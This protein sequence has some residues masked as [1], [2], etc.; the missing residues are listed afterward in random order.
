[1]A[2]KLFSIMRANDLKI[3]DKINIDGRVIDMTKQRTV[4]V[5]PGL[6]KEIDARYGKKGQ[7][8]PKTIAVG[9]S[10]DH[11]DKIHP[12]SFLV[13]DLPWKHKET[14]G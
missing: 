13:P 5:D 9:M 10:E 2:K 1:M 4:V 7:V 6:A 3:M 14:E 12:R 11:P 8:I